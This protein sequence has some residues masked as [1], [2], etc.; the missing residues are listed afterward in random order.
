MEDVG[1]IHEF[2][3][4]C[5]VGRYSNKPKTKVNKFRKTYEWKQK[6]KQIQERDKFLCKVCLANIY[7]TA[8][9]YNY[10]KLEVHHII[11]LEKDYD[12]RLD[13][14]N[15]ITLCA[16]HHHMAEKGEIPAKVLEMLIIETC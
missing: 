5:N 6:A 2:N 15:L 3:Y 1:G 8:S 10:F 12:K 7:N 14:E 16:Y 13:D 9:I 11:S 4:V